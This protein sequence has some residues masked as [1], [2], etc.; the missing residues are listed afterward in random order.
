[1]SRTPK[2]YIGGDGAEWLKQGM[3]YF[4]GAEYRLDPDQSIVTNCHIVDF[5]V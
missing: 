3:K 2:I 5:A 1:L 4:P